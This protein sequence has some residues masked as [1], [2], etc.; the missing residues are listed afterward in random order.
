MTI[1][2]DHLA[3]PALVTDS[4]P[5]KTPTSRATYTLK[6]PASLTEKLRTL[7]DQ[8]GVTLFTRVLTA[9]KVLL[10]RYTGQQYILVGATIPGRGQ[11]GAEGASASFADLIAC[12]SD[13][14]TDPAFDTLMNYIQEV[15]LP[16]A[17][18]VAKLLETRLPGSDLNHTPLFTIMLHCK[19]ISGQKLELSDLV[20]SN[21]EG[22]DGPTKS[23]LSL[24]VFEQMDSLWCLFEYNLEMLETETVTRL[25]GHW[26]TLLEGIVANPSLAISRLPLLT[27]AEQHQ[28]LVEWSPTPVESEQGL[29]RH[30]HF[31]AQAARTPQAVAVHFPLA[32]PGELNSLTYQ[33]L[34]RRANQLAHYLQGLGVGPEVLVGLF[35]E[36]SVEFIIGVIGILKAGG[37]CVPLDPAQ[38]QERLTFMVADARTPVILT[39]QRLLKQL[40]RH[41]GAVIC[42]DA[43]WTTIAR[44][45]ATPPANKVVPGNLVFVYYTSGSTGRPKAVMWNHRK[46]LRPQKDET[47]AQMEQERYLLKTSIGFT[48]LDLE[49]FKPLTTGGQIIIVAQGS[50]RDMAHLVELIARHQVTVIH[51]VPSLLSLFLQTPGLE[52]CDSLKEVICFGE[53]LPAEALEQLFERTKAQLKVSYG[54]TETPSTIAWTRKRGDQQPSN[55]VGRPLASRQVYILDTHLQP[56]PIGVVGELYVGGFIT[57]G[58]LHQ[59]GLTAERILPNPFSNAP[60]ARMYKT[61]DLGR[62]RADGTVEILGRSDDQV[63]IRGIRVELGEIKQVLSQHPE[64]SHAVVMAVESEFQPGQKRLAAYVVPRKGEGRRDEGSSEA[65]RLQHELRQFLREKL[66]EYMI[67]SAFVVLESLPL[68][69]SGKLDRQALPIPKVGRSHLAV[70]FAPPRNLTEETLTKIWIELLNL[71][72]VGIHDNFFEL[73][74]HSL[75][76]TQVV[77]KARTAFQVEL[78]LISFFERPTIAG[79]A[80]LIEQLKQDSPQT[81]GPSL[82]RVSRGKYRTK[83]SNSSNSS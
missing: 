79:L 53:A 23:D 68:L 58:Y 82:V 39:Q 36:R 17:I 63:Q 56:V 14:S 8:A 61:G 2:N 74:G 72:P 47:A 71:E 81:S 38:P 13:L 30:Q 41:H 60:G 76:A 4:Q 37:A 62:Y 70:E 49:I 3:T 59:P 55:N 25:A 66:P 21:F 65:Q 33:E 6:L 10:H 15:V 67:P 16:Q 78:T 44:Q 26:H 48:A 31:E 52:R 35:M 40:P 32:K 20:M 29:L 54:T 64:I 11:A 45:P 77:S 46:I 42:L 1:S 34:D 57:I 9:F 28:L 51:F 24:H 22:R 80:S 83:L 75:L 27:T 5:A 43:D 19:N 12:Q 50:E 73:G 7:S 69:P 18:P